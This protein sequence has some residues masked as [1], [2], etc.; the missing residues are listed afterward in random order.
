MTPIYSERNEKNSPQADDA[1]I[2][3]LVVGPWSISG[4]VKITPQT[5]NLDRFS[6]GSVLHIDGEPTVIQE[7]RFLKGNYI[8]KLD[9]V[10]DRTAAE[11]LVGKP[12][13]VPLAEVPATPENTYY[14]FELIG[15]DVWTIEGENIGTLAD[16]LPT[17]GNDVYIVRKP[18]APEVLVPAVKHV[19]LSVDVEGRKMTVNLPEGLR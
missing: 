6:V 7:S 18:G 3:G 16:V 1:I 8:V 14:Y 19:V 17:G 2:V 10:P 9:T 11:G 5:D 12:L 15:M 4:H 13:T